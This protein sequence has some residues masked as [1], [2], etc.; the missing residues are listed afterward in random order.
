MLV[1]ADEYEWCECAPDESFLA[2]V[3]HLTAIKQQ[4]EV[5]AF[6]ISLNSRDDPLISENRKY[7]KTAGWD[8]EGGVSKAGMEK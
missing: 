6:L 7:R 1:V 3:I 2:I 5:Y 4:A 8:N